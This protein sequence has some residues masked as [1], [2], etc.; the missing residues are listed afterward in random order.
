MEQSRDQGNSIRP[1]N[2]QVHLQQII[3]QRIKMNNSC[4]ESEKSVEA[5]KTE[6]VEVTHGGQV[7]FLTI[8]ARHRKLRYPS[9]E[10]APVRKTF[11]CACGRSGIKNLSVAPQA[12]GALP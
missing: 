6:N 7:W 2:Y 5:Q 8:G 12:L 4:Y 1:K 3:L 9:I 11:L 10:I